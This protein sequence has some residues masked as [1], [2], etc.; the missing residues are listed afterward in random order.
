MCEDK[1]TDMAKSLNKKS[2]LELN[3]KPLINKTKASKYIFIEHVPTYRLSSKSILYHNVFTEF[4]T[5]K[6]N[7]FTIDYE[8][9]EGAVSSAFVH[10][11]VYIF[12]VK[13]INL[14]TYTL[15]KIKYIVFAG[16][17]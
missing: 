1:C 14:P 12:E 15:I 3:R 7:H 2:M 8:S 11:K 6:L 13:S 16:E 10:K 9:L 17:T 5:R 4:E